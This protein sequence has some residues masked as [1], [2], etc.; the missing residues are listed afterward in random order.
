MAASSNVIIQ[1]SV[2]LLRRHEPFNLM[3]AEDLFFLAGGL[4]IGYFAKG[5][6]ITSSH[7]GVAGTLYIVQSGLVRG[8]LEVGVA[9]QDQLEYSEGECFP[10]PAVMTKRPTVR[11]YQALKDT[12]C[13]EAEAATVHE[14]ARRSAPFLEFC[15]GRANAL[16]RQFY[17]SL[18][19]LSAQ[20]STAELP[21]R[22]SLRDLVRRSPLACLPGDSLRSALQAM[23]AA[24]VGSIVVASEQGEPLGIFT[25]RDLVRYTAEGALDLELPVARYM[26]TPPQCLPASAQAAEASVLMAR[27]GFRHVV[28]VEDGRLAGVVSERDLF[29]LQRMSVHGIVEAIS[30]AKEH[31][32]LVRVSSDIRKIAANMLAQGV[33][34]EQLTQLIATL[35]DKLCGRI[36]ELEAARHDLAGISFCWIALGSE[37]RLE[38]TL[39]TDQD[40]GIIFATDIEISEARL[41]LVLFAAAVNQT[42]DAC[43]YPLCKGNIM[44]GNSTCCLS[45]DE[46][47]QKFAGWTRDPLPSALLNASIFFDFRASWGEEA[48]ARELRAWL[49]VEVRDNQRFL[50]A[51]A[52]A[53]L[54]SRPPLGFFTDFVTSNA[55]GAPDTLDLKAQG[56][57]PFVDAARIFALASESGETSTAQR[58]RVS[59]ER[60][61]VP[62]EE[63]EAVVEAFHFILL[64]RL[65][66][67]QHDPAHPNR[68]RPDE[69]NQ[70]DRRILKEAFRQARKLQSRLALDYQL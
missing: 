28:V 20:Q 62:R 34:A 22:A 4:K 30:G 47:K 26:S 23:Y 50:R 32:S 44:A 18:Q 33:G 41:R 49:S 1:A 6:A 61:R 46:W 69:L 27:A 55:E 29:A 42:L 17:A 8:E 40:N 15:S 36:I 58:L 64:F 51:L 59:G 5:R 2:E 11:R 31:A 38:Q 66:H 48:L 14:L 57:R 39:A 54:E 67:Q 35:N 37:G 63:I 10:L 19:A 65:R 45:L 52:Q 24:R 56:T 70:L 68:I 60:L 13:Y 25:E 12:F 7:S 16:L 21:V 43:G 9:G 53:A 3:G